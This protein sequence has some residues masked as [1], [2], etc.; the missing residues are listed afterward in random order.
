[1]DGVDQLVAG[2]CAQFSDIVG[3]E[4]VGEG[5]LGEK[6]DLSSSFCQFSC[7]FGSDS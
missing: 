6:Y 4:D 3:E 5:V 1:M 2:S 7:Y